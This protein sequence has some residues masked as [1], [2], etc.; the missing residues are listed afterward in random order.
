[1]LSFLRGPCPF[2]V[3][4][5]CLQL[6]EISWIQISTMK[7]RVQNHGNWRIRIVEFGRHSKMMEGEM[8]RT[9]HIDLK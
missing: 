1:V 2:Y 6:S 5:V 4:G 7:Y 3:T 9:H 8:R